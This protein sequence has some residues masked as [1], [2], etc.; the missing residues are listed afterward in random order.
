MKGGET[1]LMKFQTYKSLISI[2]KKIIGTDIVMIIDSW[3]GLSPNILGL[4]SGTL[5]GG[6]LLIVLLPGNESL[7][8]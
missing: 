8:N 3:S 7:E 1:K 6:A 2:K 4:A 5:K